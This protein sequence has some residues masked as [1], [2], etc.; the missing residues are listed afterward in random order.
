[1]KKVS[2]RLVSARRHT[3]G[4]IIGGKRQTVRQAAQMAR[5]GEIMNVH[6]VGGHVQSIP[7]NERLMDLP[8]KIVS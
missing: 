3:L 7:G 1:M 5:R 6:A 8:Y 2:K 4:Y